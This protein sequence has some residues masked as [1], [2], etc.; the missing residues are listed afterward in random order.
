MTPPEDPVY[1]EKRFI[2]VILPTIWH[3]SS[4]W[5]PVHVI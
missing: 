5:G 1:H 3:K 4:S 2:F